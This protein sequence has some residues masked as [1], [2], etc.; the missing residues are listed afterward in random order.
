[1]KYWIGML[2]LHSGGKRKEVHFPF[3]KGLHAMAQQYI[4][5]GEQQAT[6][7]LLIILGAIDVR[8][9]QI[10]SSVSEKDDRDD[11]AAFRG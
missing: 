2:S 4:Y 5:G 9:Y 7:N 11:T 3:P 8:K 6:H 10:T 1:M